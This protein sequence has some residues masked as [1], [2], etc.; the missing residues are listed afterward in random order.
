MK[1]QTKQM[2]T[3]KNY[4]SVEHQ[5]G[6]KKRVLSCVTSELSAVRQAEV[7]VIHYILLCP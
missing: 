1:I 5:N 6:V 2:I 3:E 4:I 7:L